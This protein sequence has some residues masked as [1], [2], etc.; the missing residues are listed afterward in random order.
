MILLVENTDLPLS[1]RFELVAGAFRDTS[2]L[3]YWAAPSMNVLD[4]VKVKLDI[5]GKKNKNT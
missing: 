3:F 5:T 2:R 4:S 1:P